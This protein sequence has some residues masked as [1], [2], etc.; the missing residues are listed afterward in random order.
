MNNKYLS[1]ADESVQLM[2]LLSKDDFDD[3]NFAAKIIANGIKKEIP[4]ASVR[5]FRNKITILREGFGSEYLF[6]IEI[7]RDNLILEYLFSAPLHLFSIPYEVDE[8][9]LNRIKE[10]IIR[11]GFNVEKEIK[12][13]NGEIIRKKETYRIEVTKTKRF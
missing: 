5:L 11:F 2:Y 7:D 10:T 4:L 3:I 8:T 1:K 12:V 6:N 9:I 13:K